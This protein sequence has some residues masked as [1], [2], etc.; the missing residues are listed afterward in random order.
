VPSTHIDPVAS[1]AVAAKLHAVGRCYGWFGANYT[2]TLDD[3]K[4]ADSI[5]YEEFMAIADDLVALARPSMPV[6]LDVKE[7]PPPEDGSKFDAWCVRPGTSI[8]GTRFTDVNMR[9]DKSGFG[10]I[11]HTI[12]GPAWHYLGRADDI[13]P[14]WEMT[15][16]MRKPDAPDVAPEKKA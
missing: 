3:L 15:H 16:W 5:G 6:W 4:R 8:P 12:D 7:L 9:G 1:D 11:D 10:F 2:K 13:Y 14:H